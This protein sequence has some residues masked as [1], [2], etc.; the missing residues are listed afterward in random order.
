[1]SYIGP[2]FL[3]LGRA[4][5]FWVG[6]LVFVVI[7]ILLTAFAQPDE[8]PAVYVNV[9]FLAMF[10]FPTAVGWLA[11]AV[12]QEFQHSTFAWPLP[13]VRRR[14]ALGFLT[15]GIAVTLFVATFVSLSESAPDRPLLLF[16]VG[17]AG[18]CVGGVLLDPLRRGLSSF[19]VVGVLA[20]I[21]SSSYLAEVGNRHPL[22]ATVVAIAAGTFGFTRL[23][24]RNTFRR[25]PSALTSPF[26]GSYALEHSA[27]YERARHAQ[28]GP[29]AR[30]WRAGYLGT[31][32]WKWA[33]AASYESMG[34]LGWKDIPRLV[35]RLWAF[36]LLFA[37][38]AWVDKGDA[39]FWMTFAKTIHE[40]V[41]E[42]PH[43]AYAADFGGERGSSPVVAMWIGGL[44]AVLALWSSSSLGTSLAYP[45]SRRSRTAVAFRAGLI[46]AAFFLLFVGGGL[47]LIG[48]VSGWFAGY[49]AR[50]DFVP[51]FFR[52]LAGTVILLPLAYWMRLRLRTS[53]E[54]KAGNGLV[55][56]ILA[57]IGF[58]AAVLI[59]SYPVAGL[60]ASPLVGIGASLLLFVASQAVFRQRLSIFFATRDL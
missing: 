39:G 24:S 6:L 45:L 10:A 41:I 15:T 9:G 50:F 38:Y 40:A 57:V 31:S 56:V 26:P 51:F 22:E 20:F 29:K 2:F 17:L 42:S 5:V 58:V 16:V 35:E 13:G 49:E 4:A 1:M 27:Q 52:P 55:L 11:G 23:F 53:A 47:S 14:L 48:L 32:P 34:P 19:A 43:V 30:S 54:N 28:S 33:R 59:W 44:G 18:F 21:A 46:D 3:L 37:I 60:V 7:A 12:V 25:K 8:L 36:W